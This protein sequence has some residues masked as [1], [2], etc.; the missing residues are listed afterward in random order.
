[1]DSKEG[2]KNWGGKGA[3]RLL[4]A[5]EYSLEK[6]GAKEKREARR[7]QKQSEQQNQEIPEAQVV[8]ETP[9]EKNK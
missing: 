9:A 6:K 5:R 4:T 8:E 1:M 2:E 7:A 3:R